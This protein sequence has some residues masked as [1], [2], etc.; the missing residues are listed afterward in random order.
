[1]VEQLEAV[2][3]ESLFT[4]VICVMELRYGATRRNDGA[5]LWERILVKVLPR[6]QILSLDIDACSRSGEIL[7]HLE[8]RGEII[9]IEDILIGATAIEHRLTV[10][11]RN[12]EHFRRIP[13]LDV[14]SWW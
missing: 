14:V 8:S 3:V 6:F 4:S 2:A 11:T 12:L 1:M 13:A 5:A 7:A 10:V 9:G